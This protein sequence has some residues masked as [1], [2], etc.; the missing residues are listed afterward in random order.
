[1]I[2]D[3]IFILLI[4]ILV[5]VI[6]VLVVLGIRE[7][8]K[9]KEEEKE[10]TT[11]QNKPKSK[12]LLIG[13]LVALVAVICFCTVYGFYLRGGSVLGSHTVE[14]IVEGTAGA[15][16]V[17]YMNQDAGI[18]Q[19]DSALPYSRSFQMKSGSFLSLVAQ[20]NSE[21][22]TITCRIMVDGKQYTE[23]TS[24]AAYGIVTCSGLVE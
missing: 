16:M 12:G 18:Q 19:E 13:L 8:V 17:T 3:S 6:V 21:A 24:T 20:K 14:Y 5:P 15:A 4:F 11:D 10:A 1:M 22:G 23:A 7:M 2:A 9:A